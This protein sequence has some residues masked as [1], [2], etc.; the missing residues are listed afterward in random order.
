MSNSIGVDVGGT[1]IAA[2]VVDQKGDIVART[3]RDTPSQDVSGIVGAIIDVTRELAAEHEIGVVGVGSAGF[4]DAGRSRVMFAPNLAWR[5]LD[6]RD[7]VE[8]ATGL[9]V[10][11]END[12]NSAA[13]GEFRFGAAS[14]VEDMVLLTIG[15][16]V[17]GA[18]VKDG[19]LYRGANGIAGE[20]GHLRMVPDGQLCGCGLRGCLEAYASGTALVRNAQSAATSAAVTFSGSAE[21]LLEMAAG[22]PGNITGPMVTAAANDGDELA[23]ELIAD[24]GRWLGE[25]MGSLIAVF[26]PATFVLGGGVAEA[27]DMLLEPTNEAMR[28]SVTGGAHR[29]HATVR[30]ATLG[31][32]AGIV[33]AADLA[34][35]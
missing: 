29:P 6:L 5:D 4:V 10:V 24:L 2:G 28:R 30:F 21:R 31:N 22:D 11:V 26:D 3:R 33:G 17:G 32:D 23:R 15:T 1:K 19:A 14:D 25:A 18:V 9:P 20:L 13:W 35:L 7:R 12:A 27:G 34:R 16:G 8:D